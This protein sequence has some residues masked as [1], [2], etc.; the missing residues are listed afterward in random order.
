[1]PSGPRCD[2]LSRMDSRPSDT[3]PSPI[4]EV[5]NLTVSFS[6]NSGSFKD[7]TVFKAVDDV[8]FNVPR[9]TTLGIVGESGSGKSTLARAMMRLIP[10]DSGS[11]I[12]DG[13]DILSA[14]RTE[15]KA[16]RRKIQ[17]VFQ[18]AAGSL[19]PRMTVGRAIAEPLEIHRLISRRDITD[20]VGELLRQVGLPPDAA[21]RY[22]H[23]FSGGQRQRIGIARALALRPKVLILDEPVSALDVSIQAQILNML[24]DLRSELGLTY[25]F[26]SHNLAVVEQFSDR[27]AVMFRGRIVEMADAEELYRRPS[28]PYTISLLAAATGR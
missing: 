23:E 24:S 11:V 15:L 22:P 9:G 21:E 3:L 7:R 28:H 18:D 12:V 6:R 19:N 13:T 27:V 20:R 14:S 26:I 17:L 16:L 4:L 10:V 8:G 2:K 5:R 1:M 25:V